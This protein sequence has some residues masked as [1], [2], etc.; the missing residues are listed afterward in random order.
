MVF[1][2]K[3][4]YTGNIH[5]WQKIIRYIYLHI[6]YLQFISCNIIGG[7]SLC[8][9]LLVKLY[10]DRSSVI[11]IAMNQFSISYYMFTSS[12][13]HNG[14]QMSSSIC[15]ILQITWLLYLG[16]NTFSTS[17]L[18]QYCNS[19]FRLDLFSFLELNIFGAVV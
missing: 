19:V 4:L 13:S 2:S 6:Y 12:H 9:P 5:L 3:M 1:I 11:K 7:S 18:M 15:V 16:C 8:D 10:F 17:L 14:N